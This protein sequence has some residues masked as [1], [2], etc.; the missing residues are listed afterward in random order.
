VFVDVLDDAAEICA[1]AHEK[2]VAELSL[3]SPLMHQDHLRLPADL[4]MNA[5]WKD[6]RLILPVRKVKL[7]LDKRWVGMSAN[8]SGSGHRYRQH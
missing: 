4:R 6:E 1:L 3:H 7:L 5:H 2:I 8:L